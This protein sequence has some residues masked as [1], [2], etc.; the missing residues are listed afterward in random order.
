M[1]IINS[2]APVFLLIACGKLLQKSGFLPESFFK[3]LNRLVFYFALPALL[4][5]AISSSALEPGPILRIILVLTL[6]TGAA[7][8]AAWMAARAIGL[9]TGRTG[10]FIQ[11]SFRGNGAF[12]GLPVIVYSAGSIH[13]EVDALATVSLAPLVILFNVLSVIVLLHYGSQRH[14]NS[15]STGTFILQLI[16]NPLITA[17]LIGCALNAGNL[18]L[19][20][21][22]DRTLEA[23]GRAALPMILLSIGS[24][25]T[26]EPLRGSASP[27]LAASLLKVV[28][29][30]LFG[31]LFAGLFGLSTVERMI[32]ILYLGAPAAGMSYVMADVMG[33]DTVLAGRI[34]TLSTLLSGITLPIIIAIGL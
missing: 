27:S 30:P 11:G 2:I 18:S 23:F 13:A 20:V 21:F 28:A 31:F 22:I 6:G 4:I 16:R 10:A 5:S 26:F 25:L 1:L 9:P 29:A 12:I 7:L 34:V 33:S 17:C 15:V 14:E 8:A 3:G 24:S 19:P 32:A